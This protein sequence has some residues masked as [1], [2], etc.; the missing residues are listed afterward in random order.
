[1]SFLGRNLPGAMNVASRGLSAASQLAANPL[2]NQL[3][4]KVGVS[5]NTM[6]QVAGGINNMQAGVNLA[7]QVMRNVQNSVQ[8]AARAAAPGVQSLASLYRSVNGA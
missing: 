8:Q 6:R 5:P 4:N 2:V 1:M 3:A 7:P